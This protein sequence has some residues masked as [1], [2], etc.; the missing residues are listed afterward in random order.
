MT[1]SMLLI[2]VA[3]VFLISFVISLVWRFLSERVSI[4]CPT[5]LAW[6]VELDNPL[7]H[8]AKAQVIIDY[9]DVQ[10]GMRIID[11]GCG[12]GRVTI[13]LAQKEGAHLEVV[14][15]DIQQGMLDRVRQKAKDMHFENIDYLN[16]AIGEGKLASNNYDR[17]LLV[18][19]LGEIPN[20][21][22][23][24]EEIFQALKPGGVVSI[25][26]TIFDPHFQSKR[27][28]V[29]LAQAAGFKE[30]K[31]IGNWVAY[32]AHFERPSQAI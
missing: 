3:A 31:T 32:T 1:Y 14:A 4:P 22:S 26:E 8:A 19:V 2:F 28:V 25:T 13:P 15:M 7:A 6:L 5:W 10:P 17:A 18:S 11:I 20:Q 23:A 29:Q 9:L 16:G 27:K 24:F 30:K 21:S 12:P